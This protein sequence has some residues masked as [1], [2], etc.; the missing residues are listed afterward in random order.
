MSKK[1]S[2]FAAAKVFADTDSVKTVHWAQQCKKVRRQ[3]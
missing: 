2:T 3:I 1:C